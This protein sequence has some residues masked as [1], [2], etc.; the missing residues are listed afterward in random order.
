MEFQGV[1]YKVHP[2]VVAIKVGT[3]PLLV[4]TRGSWETCK[5]SLRL[6]ASA[7]FV[8]R[9]LEKGKPLDT[10][11]SFWASMQ[12]KPKDDVMIIISELLQKF[13]DAGF[14]IPSEGAID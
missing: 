13:I 7:M 5:H 11:V 10:I 1:N 2:G 4:A 6:N 14:L 3:V 9:Y 8:W 12:H